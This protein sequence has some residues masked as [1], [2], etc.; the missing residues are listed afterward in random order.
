MPE[1]NIIRIKN[2]VFYAYH[3]AF[4][5]EQNLGGRFEVDVDLYCDFSGAAHSDDLTKTVDYEKVYGVMKSLVEGKKN[6]LIEALGYRIADGILESF[7]EVREIVVRVRKNNPPV[8]GVIDAVEVE[9][10]RGQT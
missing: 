6:F 3:G 5:D 4:K 10:R 2:A 8:R 7:R 1:L 9:V